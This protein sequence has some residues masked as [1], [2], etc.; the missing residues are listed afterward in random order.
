M[1]IPNLIITLARHAQ[2]THFP[3]IVWGD[4][5][6]D[7]SDINVICIMCSETE[8]YSLWQH[9]QYGPCSE[10][11]V[12]IGDH[13]F[14]IHY[15]IRKIKAIFLSSMLLREPFPWEIMLPLQTSWNLCKNSKGLPELCPSCVFSSGL[16]W[17][18]RDGGGVCWGGEGH[19]Q[20]LHWTQGTREKQDSNNCCLHLDPKNWLFSSPYD[21]AAQGWQP[22]C[23][24]W[25][26]DAA[27]CGQKEWR[28]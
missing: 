1:W 23:V 6:E 17:D 15:T 21:V 25:V 3:C 7:Y 26:C 12:H 19:G 16:G 20:Q 13:L 24:E 18:L 9:S 4:C 27:M 22:R 11:L 10:W 5:L 28:L 2:Q 14:G 8:N